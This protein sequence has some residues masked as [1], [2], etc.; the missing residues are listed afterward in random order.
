MSGSSCVPYNIGAVRPLGAGWPLKTCFL[1][2]LALK[3]LSRP[4]VLIGLCWFL[5]ILYNAP[6]LKFSRPMFC[7][8]HLEPKLWRHKWC[9]FRFCKS[10]RRAMRFLA[11]DSSQDFMARGGLR[12][13]LSVSELWRHQW[14]HNDAI[15]TFA[16]VVVQRCGLHPRPWTIVA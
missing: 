5:V 14:R 9:N 13:C 2:V 4:T 16:K 7:N 11:L 12:F 8:F 10:C 1:G 3:K 6:I 15:S